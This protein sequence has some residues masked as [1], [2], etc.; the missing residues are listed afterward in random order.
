MK[1]LDDLANNNAVN[2]AN[3]WLKNTI[4]YKN[5][6]LQYSDDLGNIT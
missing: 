4:E 3:P 1:K 5:Q 2:L 6:L